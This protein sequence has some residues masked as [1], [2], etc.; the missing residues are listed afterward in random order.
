MFDTE[1]KRRFDELAARHG[2][3]RKTFTLPADTSGVDVV[4][5]YQPPAKNTPEAVHVS[6]VVAPPSD[7]PR[8]GGY[9][10]AAGPEP[11]EIAP[12]TLRDENGFDRF[13]KRIGLNVEAQTGDADFDR[14]AYLESWSPAPEVERLLRDPELRGELKEARL[15]Q[16]HP[17][18]LAGHRGLVSLQATRPAPAD[19]ERVL[20]R[21]AARARAVAALL[22]HVRPKPVR[23]AWMIGGIVALFAFA[24][25]AAVTTN[26]L[27]LAHPTIG[28]IDRGPGVLLGLASVMASLGVVWR[29]ARGRS[30]SLLVFVMC[31]PIVAFAVPSASFAAL[32]FANE[33]LDRS[34]PEAHVVALV[35]SWSH[36]PNRGAKTHFAELGD[37]RTPGA[38]LELQISAPWRAQLATAGAKQVE[39]VTRRGALGAAWVVSLTPR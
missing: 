8:G 15:E 1:L 10:R 4:V 25:A 31:A 28:W 9:R 11:L 16:F 6:A 21:G 18:V 30:V 29:L 35:R 12:V 7:V 27:R 24:V 3:A 2:G 17:I 13:G 19:L 23:G 14:G 22:R 5:T 38:T 39:I 33:R 36:K 32:R 37:W 34:E 20:T 26:S